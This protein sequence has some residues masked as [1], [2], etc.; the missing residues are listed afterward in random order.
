MTDPGS[1]PTGDTGAPPEREKIADMLM[2]GDCFTWMDDPQGRRLEL[3]DRII[4]LL[5]PPV[6][7]P[8]PCEGIRERLEA[9]ISGWETEAAFVQSDDPDVADTL[10]ECASDLR[11]ALATRGE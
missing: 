11:A 1:P 9:V 2:D 5:R 10:R 6:P 7:S 4:A 3:A 8:D